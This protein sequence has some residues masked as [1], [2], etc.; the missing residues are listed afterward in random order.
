MRRAPVGLALLLAACDGAVTDELTISDAR[1]S[2]PLGG[3]DV[4]AAYFTLDSGGAPDALVT[5]S[6]TEAGFIEIHRSSRENGIARMERVE[7]LDIPVGE[8]VFERGGLHLMVFGVA[9]DAL[10]DGEMEI[11]LEFD[12]GQTRTEAFRVETSG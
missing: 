9:Q 4:T 10:A 6:S 8:T 5:A 1:I 2:A 12:S 11:T 3:R 7:R